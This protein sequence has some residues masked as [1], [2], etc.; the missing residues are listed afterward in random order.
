[1]AMVNNQTVYHVIS[2]MLHISGQINYHNSMDSHRQNVSIDISIH[3]S[4]HI[5]GHAIIIHEPEIGNFGM[6]PSN[7]TMIPVRLPVRSL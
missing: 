7:L 1:M 2:H 4:M 3:I 6:I 5:S